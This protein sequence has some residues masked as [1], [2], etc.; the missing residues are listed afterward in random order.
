MTHGV[1]SEALL[2]EVQRCVQISIEFY[3][4]VM[5]FNRRNLLP[6]A[7]VSIRR[8]LAAVPDTLNPSAL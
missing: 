3:V 8:L 2:T 5:H 7:L 6:A 1:N 4:T